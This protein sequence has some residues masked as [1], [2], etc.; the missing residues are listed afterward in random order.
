MRPSLLILAALVATPVRGTTPPTTNPLQPYVP[1][2]TLLPDNATNITNTTTGSADLAPH[3]AAYSTLGPLDSLPDITRSTIGDVDPAA[4]ASQTS[5]PQPTVNGDIAPDASTRTFLWNSTDT[6]PAGYAPRG[7]L[8]LFFLSLL[9]CAAWLVFCLCLML[10]ALLMM[11]VCLCKRAAPQ[12]PHQ[13][14]Q[15][16]VDSTVK[17]AG[18]VCN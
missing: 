8:P 9:A 1:Y 15:R 18:G 7:W 17:A 3:F 13:S 6:L 5:R 11:M 14:S 16:L 10:L 4:T 12:P 2:D